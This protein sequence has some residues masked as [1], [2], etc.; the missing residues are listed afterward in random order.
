MTQREQ[1]ETY[2][3]NMLKPLE[4]RFSEGKASLKLGSF[5]AGY[6][7]KIA[8][9]EA[10][11]RLLWGLTPYWAGGGSSADTWKDIF[12]QAVR[13][14]TNPEHKEFWGIV[15]NKDQRIV[16]MAALS[17]NLLWTPEVIWNRLQE[18]EKENLENWLYRVSEVSV[19]ESNWNFF[20]VL[21]NLALY[22]LGR[23]YSQDTINFGIDKYESYYLGNGWYSDGRRPQRD[24]YVSFAIHYYSLLY[25]WVMEK[26]DP[27]RSRQYKERAL[28]FAEDFIYWF[29]DCGRAIPFGRSQTYRFAQAAFWSAFAVVLGKECPQKGRV[30]GLIVRHM[31]YWMK[32]PIFDNGGVLT[33]GYAYPNL[34]MSEGYNAPGSPYW[35]FKTFLCLGLP[36]EDDFWK[37]EEEDF[38]VIEPVKA[39]PECCMLFQHFG[40]ETVALASGQY[41]IP[42]YHTHSPAK[43]AKF[44]YSSVFGFSVPRSSETLIEAAPDSMLAFEVNGKIY[45][46]KECLSA[47]VTDDCVTAVWSPVEGIVVE[48]RLI[49]KGKG[50]IRQ[51]KITVKCSC[52][53]YDCGFAYPASRETLVTEATTLES[54]VHEARMQDENGYSLMRADEGEEMI[55]RA[56]P[57][58]NLV[59]PLT[60]IPA[61]KRQL[62]AGTYEWETY[63]EAAMKAGIPVAGE[64]DCYAIYHE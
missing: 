7:C 28:A 45:V 56:V 14:G 60:G 3:L 23:K 31:D 41:T 64:G 39:V 59:F 47:K 52:V 55:I 2:L 8:G 50:H 36:A 18:E 19:P 44:A 16:E 9:I 10:E 5:A 26:E 43:Y 6:G 48:T 29:D 42:V 12:L 46:R 27:E 15:G 33:V 62:T 51:H 21:P 20:A 54:Q 32:Q 30:R 49:P 24:Y 13:N 58:T 53:A 37:D 61:V 17:L 1:L 40:N 34:N 4:G 35:S 11:L 38:P 63:C 25:T 57:N 22:K